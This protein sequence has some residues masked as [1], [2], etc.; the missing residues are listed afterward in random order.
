MDIIGAIW[1]DPY[2]SIEM[3]ENKFKDGNILSS[4]NKDM[5]LTISS[6][7]QPWKD[8]NYK[9]RILIRVGAVGYKRQNK[10]V[11]VADKHK[12]RD[13]HEKLMAS[14]VFKRYTAA[15]VDYVDLI[16]KVSDAMRGELA[17]TEQN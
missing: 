12:L 13:A 5:S 17:P 10:P 2:Q 7:I 14:A 8:N 9:Y 11:E 6:V 16:R 1:S 3:G 4:R 15:Q